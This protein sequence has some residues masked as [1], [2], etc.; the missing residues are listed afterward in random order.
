M[1]LKNCRVIDVNTTTIEEQRTTD[2]MRFHSL[3]D[4]LDP[5]NFRLT[6]EGLPA[7]KRAIILANAP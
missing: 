1:V 6:C 2:W 4:F 3:K 5:E 7:P